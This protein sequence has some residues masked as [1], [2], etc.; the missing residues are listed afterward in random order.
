KSK[1]LQ[2]GIKPSKQAAIRLLA[3]RHCHHVQAM[4]HL[5]RGKYAIRHVLLVHEK[6]TFTPLKMNSIFSDYTPIF[7]NNLL[8]LMVL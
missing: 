2:G 1:L 6:Y 7:P 4:L 8:F 3:T 5:I